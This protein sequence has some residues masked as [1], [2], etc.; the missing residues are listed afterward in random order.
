MYWELN[1]KCFSMIVNVVLSILSLLEKGI[2]LNIYHKYSLWFI[3]HITTIIKHYGNIFPVCISITYKNRD[4][5]YGKVTGFIYKNHYKS[6]IY[7]VEH[8]KKLSH[9]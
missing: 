7:I 3:S 8:I 9:L 1:I 5:F 4:T 6:V 2:L